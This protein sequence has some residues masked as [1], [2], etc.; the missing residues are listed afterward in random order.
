MS[1]SF[2][3]A[4]LSDP[5]LTSL[6]NIRVR[7]LLNKRALGYLSWCLHRRFEYRAE[8]LAALV[9]DLRCTRPEH[10]IIT[11]D[12]TH[13]G[14]PCEF[15]E[16]KKW[17]HSLGPPSQVTVIP[18]NHDAYVATDWGRTFVHWLEYMVSDAGQDCVGKKSDTR[19]LFPSL[20]I[21]RET[22]FIGLSSARPSKPFFALGNVGQVQLQKLGHILAQTGSQG[23][24][25]IVMI[26]H[27]PQPGI[28]TWRKRLTDNRELRSLIAQ[29]GVEMVLHGHAHRSSMVWLKTPA[30]H[31]PAIGVPSASATSRKSGYSAQYNIYS[32]SQDAHGWEVAIEV[33]GYAPKEGRFIVEGENRLAIPYPMARPTDVVTA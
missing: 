22:A 26:H 32:L 3:F 13:L 9:R 31:A 27:P 15:L 6:R 8:V 28:V 5:H 12:L 16:V 30:G 19:T 1:E 14:L 10:I 2:I 18:G 23:L 7:D 4:H 11:G 17:L 21:R 24:F 29:Q 33:H 20:R 25:R